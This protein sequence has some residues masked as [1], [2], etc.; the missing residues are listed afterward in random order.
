MKFIKII[1]I[2]ALLSSAVMA[3]V[4][5]LPIDKAKFIAGARF[6]FL[7]EI[8]GKAKFSE[9]KVSINGKDAAQF[10]GKKPQNFFKDGVS[11]YRIDGVSFAQKGEFE[12]L[13]S[14][15]KEKK[16]GKIPSRARIC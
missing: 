1:A 15:G 3:Q 13:A 8:D 14:Y 11:A 16:R 12:V 6:D 5:I 9:L 7:V 4:R 2:T 10:F